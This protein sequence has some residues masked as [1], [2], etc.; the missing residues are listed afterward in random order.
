MFM[1]VVQMTQEP[2]RDR[3]RTRNGEDAKA[4][5][6]EAATEEFLDKGYS[7]ARMRN[8]AA[9]AE[10]SN[11]LLYYHFG[12]KDD[13]YAA[14]LARYFEGLRLSELGSVVEAGDPLQALLDIAGL[15]FDFHLDHAE[16]ARL[17]M[18][19]NMRRGRC[20][21]DIRGLREDSRQLVDLIQR[22]VD[23][24]ARQG[25]MRSNLDALD[26]YASISSFAFFH[27]SSRYTFAR[28]F[29]HDM[30]SPAAVRQRRA[31]VVDLIR[32][33]VS[34]MPPQPPLT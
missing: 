14:V 16:G 2:R 11:R 33:Y 20:L 27:V 30:T 15:T 23:L 32:R 6:L 21:D 18:V 10:T 4:D 28:I 22:L 17:V 7:G 25:V 5:I 26:V 24:G 12:H 34:V 3:R 19:E 1:Q 29:G 9:R 8:I 13:L 31:Q